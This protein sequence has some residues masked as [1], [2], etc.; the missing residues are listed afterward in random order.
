MQS[1]RH[2]TLFNPLGCGLL[3][4]ALATP[5]SP[6]WA[7][8]LQPASQ[9]SAS[10]SNIG[11]TVVDLTP[12]DG[13]AAWWRFV[14]GTQVHLGGFATVGDYL[15]EASI[16]APRLS[17]LAGPL[18]ADATA[19]VANG[20]GSATYA[21][22]GQAGSVQ[23]WSDASGGYYDASIEY[24]LWQGESIEIGPNTALSVSMDASLALHAVNHP[25][26]LID[27]FGSPVPDVVNAQ[28]LLYGLFGRC[29]GCQQD[30]ES[31][32]YFGGGADAGADQS[33]Q[34]RLQI[35]FNNASADTVAAGFLAQARLTAINAAPPPVPEPASA[36]L[37]LTGALALWPA[38]RRRQAA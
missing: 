16:D 23:G 4:A 35:T 1:R 27:Q 10:F 32:R 17:A 24:L 9:A 37:M 8:Q 5:W 11:V 6:A 33:V 12:D 38:W 36:L 25:A 34:R 19:T 22:T 29:A 7:V 2:S 21:I 30:S 26:G 31:L 14:P 20:F 28:V 15:H 3:L 18:Q 13:V